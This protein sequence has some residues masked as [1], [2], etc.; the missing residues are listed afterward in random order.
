MPSHRSRNLR[1]LTEHSARTEPHHPPRQ[2]LI[3]GQLKRTSCRAALV[4]SLALAICANG[5]TST[6]ADVIT[7][8]DDYG[9]VLIPR[10]ANLQALKL[11]G[12]TVEIRGDICASACTLYLGLPNACII[13]QTKFGFHGPSHYGRP[14]PQADYER[15][16]QVVAAQYPLV[17]RDWFMTSGRKTLVRMQFISGQTLIGLGLKQCDPPVNS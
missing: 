3:W 13:P 1:S 9:G 4:L 6:Q 7:I 10:L 16:S 2:R 17:L 5:A 15:L 14:L 8:G 12:D 11:R